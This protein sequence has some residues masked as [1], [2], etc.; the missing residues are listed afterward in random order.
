[1]KLK[2]ALL[3]ALAA[4]A[5]ALPVAS[6]A[7]DGTITFNGQIS[8]TTCSIDGNGSGSANFTVTLDPVGVSSLATSGATAGGKPFHISLSNCTPSAGNAY[9]YFEPGT[10]VDQ[11]TGHLINTNGTAQNVQIGL[12]NSDSTPITVGS[13]TGS[14]SK[15]APISGGS[16]T[17]N[18]IA[19][20]V[21]TGGAATA[22]SVNT[23]VTYSIAYP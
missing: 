8:A 4:V 21:A 5:V 19:Q 12:L 20:Y 6:Y 17:L 1:M 10:T 3:S 2:I 15:S 18:Y 11:S 7:S 23:F 14:N 22:G 16:A 9:T 13:Q